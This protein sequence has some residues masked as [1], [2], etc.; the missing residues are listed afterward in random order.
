MFLSGY[1]WHLV[2][3]CHSTQSRKH[4][5]YLPSWSV[6]K[7]KHLS[8][9]GLKLG[10]IGN[11]W[12]CGFFSGWWKCS[13]IRFWWWLYHSVIIL[14]LIGLYTFDGRTVCYVNYTSINLLIKTQWYISD[15]CTGLQ[16]NGGRFASA[17][18]FTLAE[19]SLCTVATFLCSFI[20]HLSQESC[21]IPRAGMSWKCL[22]TCQQMKRVKGFHLCRWIGTGAVCLQDR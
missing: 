3:H 7:M 4:R 6:L 13:K 10:W 17:Q 11:K 21:K 5:K 8:C 2:I 18:E 9:L 14:N 12:A 16:N 19:D 1:E 22:L 20:I 15:T